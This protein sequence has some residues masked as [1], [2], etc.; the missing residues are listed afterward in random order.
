LALE[1]IGIDIVSL[2]RMRLLWERHGERLGGD[3]FSEREWAEMSTRAEWRHFPVEHVRLLGKRFAAKEA[4]V[5][6]LSA[7]H[8]V[9]FNWCDIEI[10][11]EDRVDVRLSGDLAAF[12]DQS[13]TRRLHGTTTS[14]DTTCMAIIIR[15]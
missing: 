6:A 9:T 3:L 11:G 2:D 5:K 10:S 13:G 14:T 7:P 15:E 1:G 8:T 4:A 12:A